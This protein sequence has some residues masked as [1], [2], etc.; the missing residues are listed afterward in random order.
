[1]LTSSLASLLL[2]GKAKGNETKEV[3]EKLLS[4][5]NVKNS[6]RVGEVSPIVLQL[7]YF[8]VTSFC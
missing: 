7:A 4:R 5:G 1:M 8:E 3:K 6:R 2:E